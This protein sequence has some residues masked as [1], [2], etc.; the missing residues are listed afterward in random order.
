MGSVRT[1]RTWSRFVETAASSDHAVQLYDDVS[2]LTQTVAAFLDAGFETG[3]P[4]IVIATADH[5][6][7]FDEA[8]RA[9]GRDVN[10]LEREGLLRQADAEHILGELMDGDR[11]SPER[12]A[13]VVGGLVDELLRQFPGR[14]IRAFG[15]M[16]DVLWKRGHGQAA[17]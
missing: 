7:R 15:E 12:F 1:A 14:T 8:L 17:I 4:A 11:P 6:R 5:R 9:V 13:E 10:A 3:A 16:V 2:E